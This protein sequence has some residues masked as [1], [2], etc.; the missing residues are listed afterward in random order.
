MSISMIMKSKSLSC[1]TMEYFKKLVKAPSGK[2]TCLFQCKD[3]QVY[4]AEFQDP[5]TGEKR[6][7]AL[8]KLNLIN[9]KDGVRILSVNSHLYSFPL[10]H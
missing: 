9:E 7:V 1:A 2:S 6:Q 3:R 4:K 5:E 8:K 10:L